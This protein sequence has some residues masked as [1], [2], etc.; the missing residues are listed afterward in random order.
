[1]ILQALEEIDTNEYL[2]R[3]RLENEITHKDRI[4]EVYEKLPKMKELDNQISDITFGTIRSRLKKGSA[5]DDGESAKMQEQISKISLEK[6]KLLTENGYSEDY[7]EPI[8][9]CPICQ[10]WGEVQGKVCSC[11]TKLRI[12]ELYQRSN[13]EKLLERENFDTFSYEYYSKEP[14]KDLGISPYENVKRNVENALKFVENFD[15]VDD[16]ILM[17]GG[18]GLGKTFLSN[19]IA[20]SLLDSGHTVLY[21]SSNELFSEI[22]SVYIMSK[23]ETVKALA[24]PIYEYIYSS[25]LLIIDDLGTEVMSSFVRSQLFEII[26]K[27]IQ[28][29]KSTL[30]SSNLSLGELQES[31]TERVMSRI[32]DKYTLYPFYGDDIRKTRF[33]KSQN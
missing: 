22:L 7:L 26:N 21:L 8:Y 25:D 2:S 10:D 15:T 4:I 19:C 32:V 9:T 16:N 27:R 1:M 17:Y 5:P 24:K 29:Q 12:R 23:N 13:L 18:P 11:V 6:K 31:Y 30:I 14:F 3:R 28:E 33:I 20:K